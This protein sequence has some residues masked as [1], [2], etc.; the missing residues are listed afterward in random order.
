LIIFTTVINII[1]LLRLYALYK[2]S[3]RGASCSGKLCSLERLI[4]SVLWFLIIAVFGVLDIYQSIKLLMTIYKIYSR[5][6]GAL[7]QFCGSVELP[8]INFS[9]S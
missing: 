4:S 2:S 8:N 9:G 3:V 5:V 7:P 6:C 1:L